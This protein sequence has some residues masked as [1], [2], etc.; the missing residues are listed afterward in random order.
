MLRTF[1]NFFWFLSNLFLY[2]GNPL[3]DKKISNDRLNICLKCPK[4]KT[5]GIFSKIKGPRC[6]L[7]GCFVYS[8]VKYKFEEC[9]D[10]PQ[11]W[12]EES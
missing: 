5:K 3:V 1:Y 12:Q 11:R 6:S 4:L 10:Y 9:P 8:K 7:C 2:R